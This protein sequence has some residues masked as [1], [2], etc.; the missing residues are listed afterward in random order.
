MLPFFDAGQEAHG[1]IAIGQVATGYVAIGQMATGVIAVGQLAR[2]VFVVGQLAVGC[3]GVGM[4]G[5]GVFWMAALMGLGGRGKGIVLPLV[6]SLEPPRNFPATTLSSAVWHGQGAG[7]LAVLLRL[8]ADGSVAL[9]EQSQRLGAKLSCRVLGR[10]R[11][12]C[13]AS[14]ACYAVAHVRRVGNLLVCDRLMNV[15]GRST[16]RPHFWLWTVLGFVALIA[17]A[18][19]VW[20]I[21]LW[22]LIMAL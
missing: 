16:D 6:P 14:T 15:P 19:A 5:L 17:V 21:A 11:S 3:C 4:V 20:E 7:W 9:Y 13:M 2:G 10:A 12:A 1:V 8:E 22:P 18:I